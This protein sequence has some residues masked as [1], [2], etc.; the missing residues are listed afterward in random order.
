[1]KINKTMKRFQFKINLNLLMI[2]I[3][4]IMYQIYQHL[5]P[6]TKIQLKLKIQTQ[7]SQI[8]PNHANKTSTNIN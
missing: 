4:H 8:Q 1:M 7:S 2:I 3:K 6:D 5:S